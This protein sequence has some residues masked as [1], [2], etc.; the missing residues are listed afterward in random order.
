MICTASELPV[1]TDEQASYGATGLT[2]FVVAGELFNI[3]CHAMK[4]GIIWTVPV[5]TLKP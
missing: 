3:E 1:T 2:E 5:A 4:E